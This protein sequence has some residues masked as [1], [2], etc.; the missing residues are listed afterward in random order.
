M[1]LTRKTLKDQLFNVK[2]EECVHSEWDSY[3]NDKTSNIKRNQNKVNAKINEEAEE[4]SCINNK[5][6]K[7]EN[8]LKEETI[9]IVW[10]GVY[11]HFNNLN[12]ESKQEME[13][14]KAKEKTFNR[15][16][17]NKNKEVNVLY[18]ES[19]KLINDNI[20]DHDEDNSN[21]D[22]EEVKE[23]SMKSEHKYQKEQIDRL[24]ET[25][26]E[27]NYVEFVDSKLKGISKSDKCCTFIRQMM[28]QVWFEAS[29]SYNLIW[30]H[31]ESKINKWKL[32]KGIIENTCLTW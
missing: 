30:N 16:V 9:K 15:K 19:Q 32:G 2:I 21:N 14:T 18:I 26:Q 23:E 3:R 11:Q 8:K 7:Y 25:N 24:F 20:Y 12:I 17:D 29:N 22:Y 1:N 27:A 28:N 10:Q 6:N 31:F 4:A 13:E 5:M